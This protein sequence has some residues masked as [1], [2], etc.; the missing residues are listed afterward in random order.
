MIRRK[1]LEPTAAR[2]WW[3]L[4]ALMGV[5]AFLT[6]AGACRKEP[7]SP[8]AGV[9]SGSEEFKAQVLES[10]IPVLVDFFATWCPPCRVLS[11][12]LE[13]IGKDY[14]GRAKVVKVDVDRLPELARRYEIKFLPTVIAFA[15]GQ[16]I[17]RW[18]GLREEAEY[19]AVLDVRLRS[20]IQEPEE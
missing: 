2:A 4:V 7:A 3:R 15:G 16:E 18:T 19:R 6:A 20:T 13:A 12:R 9:L 1:A 10:D 8:E 11:P 14:Q 5:V 17:R